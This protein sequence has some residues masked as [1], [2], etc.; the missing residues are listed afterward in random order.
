MVSLEVSTRVIVNRMVL[1]WGTLHDSIH[2]SAAFTLGR[3]ARG[4]NFDNYPCR[5]T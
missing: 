5:L 1:V 2:I 4:Y 3:L